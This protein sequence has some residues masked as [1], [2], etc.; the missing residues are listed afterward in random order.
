MS[1]SAVLVTPVNVMVAGSAD[2]SRANV[3]VYKSVYCLRLIF[4][5]II[6]N[7]LQG[8]VSLFILVYTPLRI[9]YCGHNTVV[10]N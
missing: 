6:E 1:S 10:L 5:I 8:G 4:L 2:T 3:A 7:D 9:I